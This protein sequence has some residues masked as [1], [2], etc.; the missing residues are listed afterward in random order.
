MGDRDSAKP[1]SIGP[2]V[3]LSKK[4]DLID[5]NNWRGTMLLSITSKVLCRVILNKIRDMVDPL[6]RSEQAGFRGRRSC[7][8]HK[9]TLRQIMEQ[10]NEWNATIYAVFNGFAKAFDSIHQPAM[11]KIM[12]HYRIPD[13]IISIIRMLYPDFQ[14]RVICDTNFTESFLL[15]TQVRQGCLLSPLIFVLCIVLVMKRTT[16]QNNRGL[17]WT[18]E[19]HLECVSF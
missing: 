17:L 9:F 10:G 19:K 18:F 16:N 12:T 3:K 5:T 8:D 11:W 7:A 2:I 14:V 15:Q 13:K 4:G 6:L 1:W